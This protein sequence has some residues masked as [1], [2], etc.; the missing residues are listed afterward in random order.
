[1]ILWIESGIF[2]FVFFIF[3]G[4]DKMGLTKVNLTEAESVYND[5]G[6]F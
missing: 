2:R 3:K 1:M 5:S 6:R 4:V